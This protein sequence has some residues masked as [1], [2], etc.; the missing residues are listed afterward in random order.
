M[1]LSTEPVR[2]W[3]GN[4]GNWVVGVAGVVGRGD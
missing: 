4:D 1:G 3:G 2:G